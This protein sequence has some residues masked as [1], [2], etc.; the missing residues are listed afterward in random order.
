MPSHPRVS[1]GVFQPH[2]PQTAGDPKLCSALAPCATDTFQDLVAAPQSQSRPG[3]GGCSSQT[4]YPRGRNPGDSPL[5]SQGSAHVPHRPVPRPPPAPSRCLRAPCSSTGDCCPQTTQRAQCRR[6]FS[7]SDSGCAC[8]G[9]GSPGFQEEPASSYAGAFST[10]SVCTLA[11][12]PFPGTRLAAG[13]TPRSIVP[14]PPRGS[15]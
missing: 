13:S 12:H 11:K 15:R 5:D 8:E 1:R 6:R 10:P 7:A 3:A 2:E 4:D 9:R 14:P